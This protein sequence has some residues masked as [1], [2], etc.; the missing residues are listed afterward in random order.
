MSFEGRL[1]FPLSSKP[2]AAGLWCH[3]LGVQ[4]LSISQRAQ[5]VKGRSTP[6]ENYTS[7]FEAETS[8]VLHSPETMGILGFENTDW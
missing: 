6:V 3:G 2:Q 5:F 7:S 4:S 1:L 8:F